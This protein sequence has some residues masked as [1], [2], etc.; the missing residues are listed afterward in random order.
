ML[1]HGHFVKT[2]AVFPTPTTATRFKVVPLSSSLCDRPPAEEKCRVF[3]CRLPGQGHEF[4]QPQ[5]CMCDFRGTFV[6]LNNGYCSEIT[7][8]QC[9]FVRNKVHD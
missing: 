6:R 9:Y 4:A 2:A 7:L 1:K 5:N 3:K 8:G